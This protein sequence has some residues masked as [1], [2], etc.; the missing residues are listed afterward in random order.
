MLGKNALDYPG[1]VQLIEARGHATGN[2]GFNHRNGWLTSTGAYLENARKAAEVV[3]GSNLFRP[4]YGRITPCQVNALR[5]TGMNVIMWS[6]LSPDYARITNPDTVLKKIISQ[7][8]DGSI[9]VFH[10]SQTA[11]RNCLT[12]LPAFLEHFSKLGFT[13]DAIE[14]TRANK[15]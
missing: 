7:T 11:A 6:V 3:P 4:P 1:L 14:V 8:T 13:F 9:V 2:H 10:D 12:L 5:K 15:H